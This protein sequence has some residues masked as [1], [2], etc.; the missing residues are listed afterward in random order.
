MGVQTNTM[1]LNFNNLFIQ[2]QG[3][4]GSEAYPW[5]TCETGIHPVWGASLLEGTM[6][7]CAHTHAHLHAVHTYRQFIALLNQTMQFALGRH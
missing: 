4:D 6:H 1:I 3:R 5:N 7:I 2:G